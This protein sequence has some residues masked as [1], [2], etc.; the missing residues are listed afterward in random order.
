MI[1][2]IDFNNTYETK[3]HGTYKIIYDYQY[4]LSKTHRYVRIRFDHTGTEMDVRL[5]A[6]GH[7][8]FKDP[9]FPSIYGVAY[10]GNV[11]GTRTYNK[12][13][14]DRWISMISRCHSPNDKNYMRY[15]GIGIQV[16]NEWLCFE[17]YLRDIQTLP[18][19]DKYLN[20]PFNY[21]LDKDYLQLNVPPEN[22]VY[23]KE[24][25]VWLH[26]TENVAVRT[27]DNNMKINKYHG[28]YK[29][30][31]YY[32]PT[33]LCNGTKITIGKFTDLIVAA[34][35]YNHY[36]NMIH[37]NTGRIF[38]L[39]EVPYISPHECAMQNLMIKTMAT[40]VDK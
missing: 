20:D 6:I 22:R 13:H 1:R 28:V 9:Y 17:N 36:A 27:M 26:R 19:Y 15:G 14:Y 32:Y 24:T 3:T 21:H 37:K 12:H 29:N 11:S 2:Q 34:N 35:A 7:H 25:C 5:D 38:V 31:E 39:N 16:S 23:S 30:R 40:K 33:I 10:K 4:T 8:D 18:G